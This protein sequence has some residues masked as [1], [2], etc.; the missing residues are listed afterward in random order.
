MV[1]TKKQLF[2]PDYNSFVKCLFCLGKCQLRELRM[3]EFSLK[4]KLGFWAKWPNYMGAPEVLSD[5]TTD[6]K[7]TY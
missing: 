3:V 2:G 6:G 5:E 1:K 7:T 4:Q